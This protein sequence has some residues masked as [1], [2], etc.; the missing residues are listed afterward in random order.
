MSRIRVYANAAERQRA[1]RLRLLSAKESLGSVEPQP[2]KPQ[3]AVSR[4][5]RLAAVLAEVQRLQQEYEHWLEVLPEP[6]QDTEIGAHLAETI[7]QLAGVVDLLAQ[8]QLP[9]GFGRDS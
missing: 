5:R 1:Y 7:E 9:R 4:P 8:I 2:R 3:R 6:L